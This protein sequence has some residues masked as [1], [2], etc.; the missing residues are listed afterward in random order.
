MILKALIL[1]VL[2]AIILSLALAGFFLVGDEG[3]PG[4]TV[5]ALKVRIGLSVALF[6]FLMVAGYIGLLQPAG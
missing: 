3:K 2:G 6:V 5:T 4:R 1:L